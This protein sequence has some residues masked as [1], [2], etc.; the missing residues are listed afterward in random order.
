MTGRGPGRPRI[1]RAVSITLPE[2]LIDA[3]AAAAAADNHGATATSVLRSWAIR[4]ALLRRR[5]A[6]EE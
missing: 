6:D 4:G 3:A 1:G 5:K 2:W